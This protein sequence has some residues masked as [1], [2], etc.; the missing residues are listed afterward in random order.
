[1]ENL[2]GCDDR[3]A[4]SI[5]SIPHFLVMVYRVIQA[6]TTLGHALLGWRYRHSVRISAFVRHG[7][8]FQNSTVSSTRGLY[9]DLV[10]G[11]STLGLNTQTTVHHSIEKV[12][13]NEAH[14]RGSVPPLP[15]WWSTNGR[16]SGRDPN[17]AW[18]SWAWLSYIEFFAVAFL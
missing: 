13:S 17:Q 10:C 11:I 5:N 12:I 4:H 14:G 8:T 15:A 18:Q 9:R 2:L 6:S 7:G 1:M 3:L 16:P